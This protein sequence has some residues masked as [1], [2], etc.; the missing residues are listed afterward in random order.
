[1]ASLVAGLGLDVGSGE[2]GDV[3]VWGLP[4][5]LGPGGGE[6]DLLLELEALIGPP[7][8]I[9]VPEALDVE[10]ADLALSVVGEVGVVL[11]GVGVDAADEDGV[12]R[13]EGVEVAEVG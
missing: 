3:V 1:M 2:A 8:L 9:V 10:Q 5:E 4:V 6:D 13:L 7:G 11:V 12:D